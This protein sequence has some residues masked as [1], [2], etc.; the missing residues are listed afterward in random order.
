ML[1][2]KHSSAKENFSDMNAEDVR[3][4]DELMTIDEL[5]NVFS[6]SEIV[7]MVRDNVLQDWL[8]ERFLNAEADALS[9]KYIAKLDDGSLGILICNTLDIDIMTLCDLEANLLTA[10]VNRERKRLLY[11]QT[12]DNNE[13]VVTNQAEL[14]KA[15][16]NNTIDKVFLYDNV[17]S[18]PLERT[19]ITYVGKGNALISITARDVEIIDFDDNHI[20]FYGLT[21]VFHFL[22]PQQVK[23]AHS[24]SAEHN[25][26]LIFLRENRVIKDNSVHLNE[27]AKSLMRRHPF[28]S[29]YDFAE[30]AKCLRGV[31]V[32]KAYLNVTDYDLWCEAFFLHPIWRVEFVEFLR[33]YIC[34]AKMV[35]SVPCEEAKTLFENERAQLV[36][37]DF[38][39]V[40]DDVVI[41]RLYLHADGGSG[42]IYPI[43]R[44]W[45]SASWS[46]GSGS[47][48]AG[49]GLDLID[50]END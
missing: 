36:Y 39:T 12:L 30:R 46:F 48:D 35:F 9:E 15:F 29:A 33:R 4:L 28:E 16:Q 45:Q 18:I 8:R 41:S 27:L 31:I 43:R 23:I 26:H 21:I 24:S 10:A 3:R 20:Y 1:K 34:G 40:G 38:A 6:L 17:F 42:E 14:V 13:I 32:G 37:A 25:N 5:Q 49:Y 19:D 11:E 22:N 7:S 47:G 2:E 50:I 44:L